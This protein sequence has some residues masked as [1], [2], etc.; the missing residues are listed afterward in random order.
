MTSRLALVSALSD[1]PLFALFAPRAAQATLAN[2]QG[3][4]YEF[5]PAHHMRDPL[6]YEEIL[7]ERADI[8]ALL[9]TRLPTGAVQSSRARLQG[10]AC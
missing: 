2:P 9:A 10:S 3:L 7:N 6:L 1:F 4:R 8:N 5:L